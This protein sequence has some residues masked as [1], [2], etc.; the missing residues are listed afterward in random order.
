MPR[1]NPQ[2]AIASLQSVAA[3]GGSQATEDYFVPQLATT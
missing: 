1:C 3:D 2:Q